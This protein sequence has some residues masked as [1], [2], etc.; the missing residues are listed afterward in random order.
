MMMAVYHIDGDD[1]LWFEGVQVVEDG[2]W[3]AFGIAYDDMRVQEMHLEVELKIFLGLCLV[4]LAHSW[5]DSTGGLAK[6]GNG[7]GPC[8]SPLVAAITRRR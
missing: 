2:E 3:N 7:R 4:C 1:M 6:L 5:P 8:W